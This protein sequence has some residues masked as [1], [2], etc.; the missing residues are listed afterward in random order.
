MRHEPQTAA[1][2]SGDDEKRRPAPG[3]SSPPEAQPD[4]DAEVPPSPRKEPEDLPEPL[5]LPQ[6]DGARDK[7]EAGKA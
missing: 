1:W 7:A 5:T 3:V 4:P 6:H 2:P